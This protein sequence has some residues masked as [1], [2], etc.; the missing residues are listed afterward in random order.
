ME[1]GRQLTRGHRATHPRGV[2]RSLVIEN[3]FPNLQRS[4]DRKLEHHYVVV[5]HR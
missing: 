5:W 1:S 3:N 2:V 4:E